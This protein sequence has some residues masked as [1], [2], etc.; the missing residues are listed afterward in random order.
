MDDLRILLGIMIDKSSLSD[1][2]KKLA[3]EKITM[4]VDLNFA[5][6]LKESRDNVQKLANQFKEMFNFSD[7]EALSFTKEYISKSTQLIK[8]EQKAQDSLVN[9]MS[10]GRE[11]SELAYQAEKKRQELAQNN[12]I[13]KAADQ[14]YSSKQKLID[15]M[16]SYREKAELATKAEQ[17]RQEVAQANAVNKAMD[18]QYKQDSIEAEKLAASVLKIN[19]S[20]SSG[21]NELKIEQLSSKFRS[22]GYSTEETERQLL[23]INSA[24]NTLKSSSDNSSLINNAKALESEYLKVENVISKTTA[25]NKGF[26]TSLQKVNLGNSISSW[27]DNNSKSMSRYGQS[28]NQM[29]AKLQSADDLT[30]PELKKIELEFKNIQNE[31][32]E[33]G[34]LGKS[35]GDSF[36]DAGKKFTSWITVTGGIM[37]LV[38]NLKDAVSELKNVN[39]ILTEISKTNETLSKSD[40]TKLGSDAFDTASKYGQKAS[41]YLLG[42]QE[43][44]RAGYINAEPIAELSTLAQS[45]GDMTAELANNYLI[46]TD[47]AYK[48]QGQTEKLNAV[49]DGQNYI[50]NRNA[51]SMTDLADATR[52]SASQAA[53]AGV[54]VDQMTAAVG[55]MIATTRESGDTMGRAFKAILM[56][57]QQVKGTVDETTG[58][59]VGAEDLTKYE[60]AANALGVKLK[61]VKDGY[62]ALRDPMVVL[63]EL[64]KAYTS[65]NEDDT[66]RANLISAIGGKYRGNALNALLENWPKYEKMLSEYSQGTGSAMDEANGCLVA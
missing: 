54:S 25:T 36:S 3:K 57:V 59:V 65:L 30:V 47:A 5:N 15:Q 4:N 27:A 11:A 61:E 35:A 34:L 33:A 9:S 41:D 7:R 26:A 1:A 40:L 8:Q 66:R 28:I 62:L 52:V 60:E 55:T 13:N 16:A 21:N 6:S 37:F 46:A 14:E 29:I 45:A 23:Q 42:V 58:E 48:L 44:S 10:K 22:L 51:L 19:Q 18:Q 17:K 38:S 49:L 43:A 24:F 39:T 20:I 56:N 53:S 2:Q 63:K 50:T 32:R 31:S 12:A 64:S